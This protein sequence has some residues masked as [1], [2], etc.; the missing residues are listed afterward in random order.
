MLSFL[1]KQMHVIAPNVS[2]LVGPSICAKL[3]SAAG[4]IVELSRTPACNI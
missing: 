2:A 1:E 3:L 4:G